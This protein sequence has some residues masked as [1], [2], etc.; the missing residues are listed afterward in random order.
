MVRFYAIYVNACGVAGNDLNIVQLDIERAFYR[1]F[2]PPPLVR[3]LGVAP[4][5]ANCPAVDV[6][7]VSSR[8]VGL[9]LTVRSG[10]V[11]S[12]LASWW[13]Q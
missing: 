13:S 5:V 3:A 10:F 4:L 12:H 9:R 8:L 1:I 2:G 6:G 7:H 11:V